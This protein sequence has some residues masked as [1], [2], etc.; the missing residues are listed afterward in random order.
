MQPFLPMEELWNETV[1]ACSE[2]I[3]RSS[4]SIFDRMSLRARGYEMYGPL[5]Q[6]SRVCMSEKNSLG[7]SVTAKIVLSAVPAHEE[8]TCSN[9]THGRRND[10]PRRNNSTL[11]VST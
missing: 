4:D 6:R 9:R 11:T 5:H 7:L 2:Q 3:E 1:A 10:F 8:V